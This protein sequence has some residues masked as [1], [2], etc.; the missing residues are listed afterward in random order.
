MSIIERPVGERGTSEQG[1]ALIQS[2]KCFK[3]EGIRGGGG[4]NVTGEREIKRVDDHG[5]R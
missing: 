2:S 3:Y 1:R 5:F 4:S